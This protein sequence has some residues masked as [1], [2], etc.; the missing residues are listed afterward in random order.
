M[1]GVRVLPGTICKI[2]PLFGEAG[3]IGLDEFDSYFADGVYV[4][5]QACQVLPCFVIYYQEPEGCKA[6][7][8]LDGSGIDIMRYIHSMD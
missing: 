2:N 5:R 3:E 7:H 8:K 6:G 1:I 4:V